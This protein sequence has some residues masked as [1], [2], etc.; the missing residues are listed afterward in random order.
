MTRKKEETHKSA[1]YDQEIKR[2]KTD[3]TKRTS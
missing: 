1:N 3:K 2:N